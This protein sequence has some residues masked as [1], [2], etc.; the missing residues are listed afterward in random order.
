[1]SDGETPEPVDALR[2]LWIRF[3]ERTPSGRAVLRTFADPYPRQAICEAIELDRLMTLEPRHPLPTDGFACLLVPSGA[4]TPVELQRRT[5]AWMNDSRLSAEFP[6]VDLV[7][8]SDRVLWRPGRA[9]VIGSPRRLDDLLAGLTDFSYY[10]AEL[11][12]LEQE[13]EADWATAEADVPLTHSVNAEAAQR[14]S[15]VDQMTRR[16][17]LRRI[18]FARL[19]PRLEKAS[20]SL[21]GPI[22][23]LVSDLA[24]QAEIVDRLRSLDDRLEVFEDLYELANDRLS[25]FCSFQR[26]YRL[27]AWILAV[28]FVEVAIMLFEIWFAWWLEGP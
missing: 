12:K 15:H 17:A 21:P 25:E 19:S 6:L 26:E 11:R 24:Q 14:R 16:T 5:E 27:E 3:E 20:L 8:Q 28:L 7:A 10:E 1:M 4:A 9:V 2:A 18:R 22:R 23:R 13:L